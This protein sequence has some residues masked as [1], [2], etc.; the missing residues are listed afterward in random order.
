MTLVTSVSALFFKILFFFSCLPPPSLIY[1]LCGPLPFIGTVTYEKK[2][3]LFS[4][5]SYVCIKINLYV[6]TVI[7]NVFFF[8]YFVEV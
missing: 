4:H 2:K 6:I 8:K 5:C 1:L 7:Y 3:T